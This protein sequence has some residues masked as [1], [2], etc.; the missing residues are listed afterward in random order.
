MLINKIQ[1]DYLQ[2]IFMKREIEADDIVVEYRGLKQKRHYYLVIIP[3][4]DIV[5][6]TPQLYM[7]ADIQKAIRT[8]VNPY[9]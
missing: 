7:V 2:K 1:K 5:I 4:S 9:E 6:T 3:G 8:L